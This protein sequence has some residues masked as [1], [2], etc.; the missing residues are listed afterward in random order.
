VTRIPGK[1]TGTSIGLIDDDYQPR[2]I[3]TTGAN[4]GMSAETIVPQALASS[5]VKLFHIAGF[6]VLPNLFEDVATKLAELRALGIKTSLDVVFNVRMD[7]PKLR[8]ALWAA[9]PHLDTFMAND[10]EA[11]RLTGE[12]NY[13]KAAAILKEK[14]AD[15]IVIKRGASG[16]YG[17]SETY[18][19]SIPTKRVNVLDTTGAGDAFAAGFI[20]ALARNEPFQ[21]ACLAGNQA[22]AKIC[23]RLGAITAWLEESER[24]S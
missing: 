4:Q 20:A 8:Q 7:D 17:L 12:P 19:G 21:D 2:F 10:H 5:G 23:T 18:S 3:H 9:L 6:F 15:K 14:G 13:E 22:G 11:T 16:C 1:T 24:M